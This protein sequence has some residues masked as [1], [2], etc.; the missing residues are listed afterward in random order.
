[1][2]MEVE[3]ISEECIKPSSPTPPNLRTHKLSLLDQFIP[4]L[5]IPIILFYPMNQS[6]SHAVNVV[7]IVSQR[8]LMLKQSLSKTLTRFYP[9]AG[10]IKDNLS[11][12]CN[13]EGA[14][15][16]EARANCLLVDYLNQPNVPSSLQTFLPQ[17]ISWKQ[18]IAGDHVAMIKVTSF[19]CGGIA[20]GVLVSHMIADGTAMSVFLKGWAASSAHKDCEHLCPNFDAPSVFIQSDAFSKEAAMAAFSKSFKSGNCIVRRF[21]FD[22]SA[23]ASLKAKATSSSVQHPTRVEVVSAFLWKCTMTA[24]QAT[25][26]IQRPTFISHVVNLRRRANPPFTESSMGNIIWGTDALCTAEEIDLACMVSKLRE[27]IMKINPDF[28]KSLQGDGGFFKLCEVFKAR[29][30]ALSSIECSGGMDYIAFTSWFNFG[31]YDIDFGWGKPMWV[32]TVGSSNDSEAMFPNTIILMDTRSG[33]GI[34][35]WVSLD[36]K[37]MTIIAQDKELLALATLDPSPIE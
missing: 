4:S 31:L 23:I 18:A 19:A 24:F 21:V 29:T 17:E 2:K 34:E 36:K 35:A 15:Y 32:S 1:M 28:V 11:I 7:D 6:T 25:S 3:I 9:F 20:I 13:D 8:S 37:D 27:A 10:K 5:Y 30:G 16:L 12:D 22:A 14:L 33:D 26:G